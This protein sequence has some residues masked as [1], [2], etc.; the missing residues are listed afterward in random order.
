MLPAWNRRGSFLSPVATIGARALEAMTE[1]G[2]LG[3]EMVSVPKEVGG[4][5]RGLINGLIVEY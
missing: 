1:L 4:A 5:A 3:V 2:A